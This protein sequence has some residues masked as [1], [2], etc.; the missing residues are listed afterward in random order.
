M[1]SVVSVAGSHYFGVVCHDSF[2]SFLALAVYLV[3]LLVYVIASSLPLSLP[4]SLSLSLLLS[5]PSL[6]SSSL[7]FSSCHC[8]HLLVV[9]R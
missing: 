4:L 1:V 7:L 6:A 2:L 3:V 8:S 9:S 5:L